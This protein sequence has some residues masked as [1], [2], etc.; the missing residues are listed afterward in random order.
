MTHP[1]PP[2]Y[3]RNQDNADTYRPKI[4]VRRRS[5]S[6]SPS[7]RRIHP[8]PRN[9]PGRAYRFQGNDQYRP[10]SQAQPRGSDR[11]RPVDDVPRIPDPRRFERVDSRENFSFRAGSQDLRFPPSMQ[12]LPPRP[13]PQ[14]RASRPYGSNDGG[15]RQHHRPPKSL[16]VYDRPIM[17]SQRAATPEQLLGMRQNASRF[18][19]VNDLSESEAEMELEDVDPALDANEDA[20]GEPKAKRARV[21]VDSEANAQAAPKWSNPDPYTSLPPPDESQARKKDV[22]K[23]IRKAKVANEQST[24]SKLVA[25]SADF[26]S[27]SFDD[28]PPADDTD[29]T[30]AVDSKDNVPSVEVVET[31]KFSHR[32]NLH[33]E[34]HNRDPTDT[35]LAADSIAKTA[36]PPGLETAHYTAASLGPPPSVSLKVQDSAAVDA[37]SRNSTEP[38]LPQQLDSVPAN[39]VP[40]ASIPVDATVQSPPL[41]RANPNSKKRKRDDDIPLTTDIV[42]EWL[43]RDPESAA[44]WCQVDHSETENMGFWLVSIRSYL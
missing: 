14:N 3:P 35:V 6:R 34:T 39:T 38:Q 25:D 32:D 33:A 30:N 4:P 15:T 26:I 29:D 19:D 23:M 9:A 2:R 31:P 28:N 8:L 18:M 1:K 42:P 40:P 36:T 21:A 12:P 7:P 41:A 43:P 27:F 11:Y 16:S 24:A 5:R 10:D 37:I 20:D 17:R 44:P 22:L 13:P